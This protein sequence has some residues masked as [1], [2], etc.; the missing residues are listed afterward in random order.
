MFFILV[1]HF[2]SI[3]ESVTFIHLCGFLENYT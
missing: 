1:L 2:D 3:E